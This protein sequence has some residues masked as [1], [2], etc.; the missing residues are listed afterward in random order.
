MLSTL[1]IK[2]IAIVDELVVE[3][4]RGLNV[5]T[6]ETGAGKSIV[7][8]SLELLVGDPGNGRKNLAEFIRTGSDKAEVEGMFEPGES[9]RDTLALQ[10]GEEFADLDSDEIVV[11]RVIDS[12]G[13]SKFTLNG[14]LVTRGQIQQLGP[15]LLESTGQH[16]QQRLLDEHQH[17]IL[18]DDFGVSQKLR[19][20][21]EGAYSEYSRI[22]KRLRMLRK[23]K[24]AQ[25]EYFRRVQFEHEELS[26]A[27][28]NVGEREGL[29]E[30]IKRLSHAQ[31]IT[32]ELSNSLDAIETDCR[33][34]NQPVLIRG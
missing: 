2:N 13:K 3:F 17:L 33:W 31:A 12:K 15:Y 1:R 32:T 11:R 30:Q 7:L 26:S 8:R 5:L 24:E 14:R 22:E 21:V 28:L 29:E 9:F 4:R 27:A 23:D 25:A 34:R 6:G 10:F 19:D 20:R 16:E 18:L